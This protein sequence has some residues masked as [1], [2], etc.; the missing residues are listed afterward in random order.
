[1]D[2]PGSFWCRAALAASQAPDHVSTIQRLATH[3]TR[4]SGSSWNFDGD[5]LG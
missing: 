1:V 3:L 5:L 2:Q 4:L